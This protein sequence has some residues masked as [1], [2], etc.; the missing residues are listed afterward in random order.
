[1][2]APNLPAGHA[3]Q[4]VV[5]RHD[6]WRRLPDNETGW[7]SPR[8]QLLGGAQAERSGSETVPAGHAAQQ[9]G[10]E[11]EPEGHVL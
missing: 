3:A 9:P 2:S 11:L 10:Q 7:Y 1:M 6:P 4:D 8:G 5:D